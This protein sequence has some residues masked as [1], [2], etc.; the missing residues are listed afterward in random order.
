MALVV[1]TVNI[2]DPQYVSKLFAEMSATYGMMN[3]ITSFGFTA[4]W[5]RFCVE[6]LPVHTSRNCAD[7]MSGM[8]E[9]IPTLSKF[10]PELQSVTALDLC[11]TMC[12]KILS[13][14][15][16][17][18]ISLTVLE[19]D[20][21][22]STMHDNQFDTVV[23]SFGLKTFSP[24]QQREL[25][26]VVN[27]ILKPG[28]VFAFVE[29][30]VPRCKLLKTPLLFYLRYIIP[31]LGRMFL[32]NPENYRMLSVYTEKFENAEFFLSCLKNEGLETRYVS[33]FFGCATGVVGR[34]R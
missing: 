1:D 30:S 10:L 32:G 5:R 15:G 24:Q 25:A 4:A 12:R 3:L 8:G 7:L 28:G 19:E 14:H 6:S 17:L 31:L 16:Q 23:S 13:N 20:V 2:Y 18:P 11:P 21:F 22:N 26:G 27:K 34:K 9:V 33:R 29:L